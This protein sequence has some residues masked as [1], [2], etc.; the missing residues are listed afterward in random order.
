MLGRHLVGETRG[1]L[2]GL[3]RL[4]HRLAVNIDFSLRTGREELTKREEKEEESCTSEN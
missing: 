2:H 1:R 3:F 4:L